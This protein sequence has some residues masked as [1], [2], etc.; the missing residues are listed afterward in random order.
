FLALVDTHLMSTS[1]TGESL[2][3]YLKMTAD[4]NRYLADLK[5]GQQRQEAEQ[6]TLM[7]FQVAQ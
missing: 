4:Y 3:L 7:A 6:A 5:T 1:S 2:V